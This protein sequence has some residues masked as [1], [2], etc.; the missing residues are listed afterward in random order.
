MNGAVF[1]KSI[2]AHPSV[3]TISAFCERRRL[4]G[5]EVVEGGRC[6]QK[7]NVGV[8]FDTINKNKQRPGGI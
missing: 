5:R 8:R 2:A 4:L 7:L 3:M 6:V 1:L